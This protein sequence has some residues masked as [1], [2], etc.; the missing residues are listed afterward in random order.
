MAG[1]RDRHFY[2]PKAD[3]YQRGEVRRPCPQQL[4]SLH[5]TFL[6]Y[7]SSDA[8]SASI[9]DPASTAS[10]KTRRHVVT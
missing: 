4:T 3:S 5:F 6:S 7:F 8:V 2:I 9:T 10:I 1:E